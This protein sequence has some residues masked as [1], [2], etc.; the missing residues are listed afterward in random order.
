M[1]SDRSYTPGKRPPCMERSFHVHFR[2]DFVIICLIY[3]RL[4]YLQPQA[5][6]RSLILCWCLDQWCL[7]QQGFS[8][9]PSM[10]YTLSHIFTHMYAY[11]LMYTYTYLL[12]FQASIKGAAFGSP[13]KGGRAAFGP[14]PF[15]VS[16]M[17][18]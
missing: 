16:F 9:D 2:S 10:E 17:E 12:I 1:A 3:P 6:P 11:Y 4:F 14:P 7:D 5:L 15:V 8:L 18:A 13:H